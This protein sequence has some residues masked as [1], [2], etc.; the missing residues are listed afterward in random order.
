[1]PP[2]RMVLSYSKNVFCSCVQKHMKDARPSA[3]RLASEQRI[4]RRKDEGLLVLWK[5]L[6]LFHAPHD[7]EAGLSCAL[8]PDLRMQQ[9]VRAHFQSYG[10]AHSHLRRQGYAVRFIG[11]NQNLS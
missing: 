10:E 4:E 9:L 1:M 7:L 6:N 8:F 2:L 11:R 3:G 5:L